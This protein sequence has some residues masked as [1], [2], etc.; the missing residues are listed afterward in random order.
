MKKE[1]GIR[2]PAPTETH[3][4]T[5]RRFVKGEDP[6]LDAGPYAD[7]NLIEGDMKFYGAPD[8]RAIVWLRPVLPPIA[9]LRD[10]W[11]RTDYLPNGRESRG[12]RDFQRPRGSL[13]TRAGG[14]MKRK[15]R[16]EDARR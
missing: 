14:D 9:T 5:S 3:P 4:G 10:P 16:G 2:W 12:S 8:N 7:H 13:G 15:D 1:R 6:L 11:L